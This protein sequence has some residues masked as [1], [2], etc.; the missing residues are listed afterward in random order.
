MKRTK[1]MTYKPSPEA[2]E[3]FL[4]ITNDSFLYHH[5]TQPIIENLKK[6]AKKDIYNSEKAVDLFYYLATAGSNKY[7]TNYG[8]KFSVTDRYTVAVDLES[9]YKDD[10]IFYKLNNN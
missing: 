5:R 9:Y 3:L 1:S 2:T 6:K 4:F 8:Y 10:E 7:F